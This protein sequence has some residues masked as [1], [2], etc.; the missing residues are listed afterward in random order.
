MTDIDSAPDPDRDERLT[1]EL[2]NRA[3]AA[4]DAVG[5]Y[6]D[7]VASIQDPTQVTVRFE[8]GHLAFSDRVLDPDAE[9][10]RHETRKMEQD[11]RTP[12]SELRRRSA[13]LAERMRVTRDEGRR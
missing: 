2:V 7:G 4:G 6:F 5:L 10:V 9:A 3:T 1:R 13:D 12:T 11:L 8:V